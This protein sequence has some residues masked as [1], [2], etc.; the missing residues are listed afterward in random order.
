MDDVEAGT[1]RSPAKDPGSAAD[2]EHQPELD[3]DGAE[4]A[5]TP[6]GRKRRRGSRGGQRRRKTS[7]AAVAQR[8]D[9]DHAPG[10]APAPPADQPELPENPREGRLAPEVAERTLVRKPQIGDTRPAP[11]APAPALAAAKATTPKQPRRKQT[12]RSRGRGG[13]RS[14]AGGGGHAGRSAR[15]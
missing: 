8:G 5:D 14:V 6:A 2:A 7:T 10:M 3:G 9:G 4:S 11:V 13:C 1:P 15:P 12:A